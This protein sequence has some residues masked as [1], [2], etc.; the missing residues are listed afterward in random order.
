ME[1]NA[2][3]KGYNLAGQPPQTEQLSAGGLHQS[4]REDILAGRRGQIAQARR[5]R[6]QAGPRE[7]DIPESGPLQGVR[8]PSHPREPQRLSGRCIS[9]RP[10]RWRKQY[11]GDDFVLMPRAAYT[12]SSPYGVFWGGDIG[13]TPGRVARLDHRRAARGGDGLSELGFRHLRLQPATHGTRKCAPA[14]W[15]SV[16]SRRS[17]KSARRATVAFWNLPRPAAATTPS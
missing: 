7:E 5:G 12:G 3:A 14:G 13:G 16:A 4:R 17:W 1:T 8:R 2:L 11:R 10:T 6:V 9:R 15:R